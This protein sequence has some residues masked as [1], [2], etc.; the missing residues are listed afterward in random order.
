MTKLQ[1]S[2]LKES[3]KRLDLSLMMRRAGY[4]DPYVYYYV[5]Y[6]FIPYRIVFEGVDFNLLVTKLMEKFELKE[7][8]IVK[9]EK[10]DDCKAENSSVG[11]S[12]FLMDNELMLAI[13]DNY[14][15]YIA[16]VHILYSD[17]VNPERV[18]ELKQIIKQC[19]LIPRSIR[20][21]LYLL[22]R[23]RIG[24]NFS[25]FNFNKKQYSNLDIDHNYNDSFKPINELIL[26]RLSRENDKGLVILYGK[27]GTGKTNYIRYICSVVNKR[28]LFVPPHMATHITDPEFISLLKDYSN[29]ILIIE[30]AENVVQQRATGRHSA[31][32]NL[33]NLSDGLLADCF[34]IQIV[35]T[36][37][38][39]IAAIDKA[40]LRKGRLIAKYEFKELSLEKSQHLSANLGF[41][42]IVKKPMTLA[43]IYNQQEIEFSEHT[44][45]IGFRS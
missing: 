13:E 2:L 16:D 29:S 27:T 11:L 6:K 41:D 5:L 1:L 10:F 37:N 8:T 40:L 28:K 32:S 15:D 44:A 42:T 20:E 22:V 14:Q 7:K 35:C 36:F 12:A 31:V 25:P 43:E 24:F 3:E 18:A 45:V 4:F 33:L 26:E 38:C 30:D 19:E 17:S 21:E 9:T 23:D 34:S 39:D